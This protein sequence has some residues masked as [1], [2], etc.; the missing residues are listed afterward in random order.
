MSTTDRHQGRTPRLARA[1][2]LALPL[3]LLTSL[4]ALADPEYSADPSGLTPARTRA[5]EGVVILQREQEQDRSS[6]TLNLPVLP[7]DILWTE[8]GRVELQFPDGSLLWLAEDT[9][10]EFLGIGDSQGASEEGTVLKLRSGTL[11]VDS[12]GTASREADP[13]FRIDTPESTAYLLGKGRFRLDS[14]AGSTTLTSLRGVAELAGD[15]GSV[16]V[17]SGQ[18]SRAERG[19]VPENP[20]VVNTLRLDSFD[21]WCEERLETY[22]SDDPDGGDREYVES[23]PRPVRPYVSELDHYGDWSYMAEFGW[24]WRPTVYQVGWRPYY[25]GYW[26]WCPRGWTWVAYEPWGWGPYHYGRWHFA[27]AGWIWIPGGIYSGAWVDWAVTPT[28]VGWCPLDFYNRPA[29]IHINITNVTV[30]RFG[31]AWNFLPLNRFSDRNSARFVV[32]PERVPHL[33]GAVTTRALPRFSPR[34]V[35]TRPGVSERIYREARQNSG[36][37]TTSSGAGR[38]NLVPFRQADR[39]EAAALD[40]TRSPGRSGSSGPPGRNATGSQRGDPTGGGRPERGTPQEGS[41]RPPRGD[42]NAPG[43]VQPQRPGR[44]GKET[45]GQPKDTQTGGTDWRPGPGAAPKESAGRPPQPHRT[46]SGETMVRPRRVETPRNSSPRASRP[47]SDD[48]SQRVLRR[49]FPERPKPPEVRRDQVTPPR[50]GREARG[51]KPRETMQTPR[52][53]GSGPRVE[54]RQPRAQTK[55]PE[56]PPRKKEDRKN[57]KP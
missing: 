43:S 12:R 1:T 4:P 52:N 13:D 53:G 10:V 48:P 26:T 20:W 34:E 7:G 54:T 18:Q 44:G 23:V 47:P 5:V 24:V 3:L 19:S 42:A 51:G 46:G 22:L 25:S 8:E 37:E 41:R 36:R 30:N 49:I 40:R 14:R 35:Q 45:G 27:A 2:L 31:G 28:Y 29:Y 50:D 11:E 32:R 57:D 9:R 21:E 56:A 6:A 38:Q 39:R 16:L 15:D 33:G 55:R 17:R